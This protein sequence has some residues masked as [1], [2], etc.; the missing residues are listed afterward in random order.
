[1]DKDNPDDDACDICGEESSHTILG[2]NEEGELSVL[3]FCDMHMAT[4]GEPMFQSLYGDEEEKDKR[5]LN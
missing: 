5:M 1:M 3:C 4:V 2:T